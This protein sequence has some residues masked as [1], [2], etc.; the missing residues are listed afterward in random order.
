MKTTLISAFLLIFVALSCGNAFSQ[1]A[2][3]ITKQELRAMLGNPDVFIIDVRLQQEWES[4]EKKI[5]GAIR[6]D[7]LE[8]RS[9]M[10][11]FSK[12]KTLVFYCS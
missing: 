7:P 5:A 2:P 6:E 3:R 11:K 4:S 8:V 10:P 1:E 9:W 12:D